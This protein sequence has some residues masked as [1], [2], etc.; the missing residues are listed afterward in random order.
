MTNM[1]PYVCEA[2]RVPKIAGFWGVLCLVTTIPSQ[3]QLL[4]QTQISIA[5]D[6]ETEN[7]SLPLS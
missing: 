6:M 4:S 1:T 7:P 2:L 5:E 3:S